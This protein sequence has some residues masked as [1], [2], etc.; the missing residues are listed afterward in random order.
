MECLPGD[1]VADDLAPDDTWP[2][3]EPTGLPFR[4]VAVV[5]PVSLALALLA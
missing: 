1:T 4:S 5:V 3:L 2:A